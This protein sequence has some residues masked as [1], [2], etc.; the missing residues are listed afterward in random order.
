MTVPWTVYL[1]IGSLDWIINQGDTPVLPTIGDGL[2]V[3]W[4][5]P[6]SDVWPVQPEPTTLTFSIYALQAADL[7]GI[8]IGTPL[9][10]QVYAGAPGGAASVEFYGRVAALSG[11]PVKIGPTYGSGHDPNANVDG[12]RLDVTCVDYSADLAETDV[13]GQDPLQGVG[14]WGRVNILFGLAGI[15]VPDW[16]TGG[17]G[18]P[19]LVTHDL[20][21]IDSQ[22]LAD[23]VENRLANYADL[24]ASNEYLTEGYRRGILRANID[25]TT[26]L[27]VPN[28]PWRV[29][30]VSRRT[31]VAAYLP[32]AV[33]YTAASKT[34]SVQLDAPAANQSSMLISAN[35]IDYD[36]SWQ[37]SKYTEPNIVYVTNNTSDADWAVAG[38]KWR[39]VYARNAGLPQNVAARLTESLLYNRADAQAVADMYLDDSGGQQWTWAADAFTWRASRDPSWPR[40]PALFPDAAQWPGFSI[41]II[42]GDIP[43]SQRPTSRVGGI[44]KSVTWTFNRGEFDI[45]LSLTPR[46]PR[47]SSSST[48]PVGFQWQDWP[49]VSAGHSPQWR[50]A[51]PSTTDH[52]DTAMTWLDLRLARN[53]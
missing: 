39:Q 42:V 49:N 1:S 18:S 5:M 28:T 38:D 36:A 47:P 6:D 40:V 26:G 50:P 13:A 46:I 52:L 45:A 41:P 51:S 19:L 4:S 33:V 21:V 12:W 29:S 7:T 23:A 53:L 17:N 22:S 20:G 16:G 34:Y 27:P 10:L 48:S 15:P 32:G 43:A 8:D 11:A 2:S 3:G 37:R 30:W 14:V 25:H 35:Y 9:A 44:P 31:K 24:G